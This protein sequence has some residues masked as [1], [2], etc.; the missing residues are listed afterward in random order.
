MMA[1]KKKAAAKA[2][3]AAAK[4]K[5]SPKPKAGSSSGTLFIFRKTFAPKNNFI[6]IFIYTFALFCFFALYKVP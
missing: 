4:P 6:L 2:K 3:T 5:A 1:P